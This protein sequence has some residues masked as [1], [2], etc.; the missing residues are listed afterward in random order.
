[1]LTVLDGLAEFERETDPARGPALV[2]SAPRPA[3]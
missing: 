1:M 3:A 2:V